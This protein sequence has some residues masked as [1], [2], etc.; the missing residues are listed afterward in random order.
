MKQ[1]ERKALGALAHEER[2]S[3]ITTPLLPHPQN[4]Q[5]KTPHP[6]TLSV[7]ACAAGRHRLQIFNEQLIPE[8]F[9]EI[10]TESG[11]VVM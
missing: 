7:S 2:G 1:R 10:F 4:K 5:T 11:S 6:F 9:L 8:L 3:N